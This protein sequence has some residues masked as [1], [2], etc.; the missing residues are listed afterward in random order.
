MSRLVECPVCNKKLEA[1]IA[2]SHVNSCLDSG[3][4]KLP[5]VMSSGKSS[6][7]YIKFLKF[8]ILSEFKVY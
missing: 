2:D 4:K 5:V 6:I 8:C 3:S 1:K 7:I